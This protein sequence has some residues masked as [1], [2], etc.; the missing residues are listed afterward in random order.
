MQVTLVK[1]TCNDFRTTRKRRKVTDNN[2]VTLCWYKWHWCCC[3]LWCLLHL[4]QHFHLLASLCLPVILWLSY[5]LPPVCSPLSSFPLSV[6]SSLPLYFLNFPPFLHLHLLLW[7]HN[8]L[9]YII[10]SFLI[11]TFTYHALFLISIP[12]F[13]SSLLPL[14]AW[15]VF[16]FTTHALTS[17]FPNLYL[18]ISACS[19]QPSIQSVASVHLSL[20]AAS[21]LPAHFCLLTSLSLSVCLKE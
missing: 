11:P 19:A 21:P 20:P 8:L 12:V 14:L 15:R 1:K 6:C 7:R 18:F 3:C 16:I 10:H 5:L 9:F 2:Y 17:I 4:C 13:I